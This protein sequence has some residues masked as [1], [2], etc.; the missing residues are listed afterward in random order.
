M[1][2]IGSVAPWRSASGQSTGFALSTGAVTIPTPRMS[3]Y[4]A[5]PA[6]ATGPVTDS[7]AVPFSVSV[8]N[9]N[10]TRITTVLIRCVAVT[11]PKQCTDVEWR[12]GPVGPWRALTLLDNSVESRTVI[13]SVVNDP[14]SGTIWLRVRIAWAD[15]APSLVASNIALTLS[16]Y[17]P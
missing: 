13:P 10:T 7:V 15:P 2:L 8:L 9:Q 1:L 14:W 6:S 17:R 12:N 4:A 11:G 5:W 3:N 16:V